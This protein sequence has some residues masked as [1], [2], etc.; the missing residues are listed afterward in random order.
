M[1]ANPLDLH[2]R[3]GYTPDHGKGKI[4]HRNGLSLHPS[5]LGGGTVRISVITPNY[6]GAR[7]LEE[8]IESVAIQRKDGVDVEY[9]VADGGST[10]GSLEILKKRAGDVSVLITEKDTGPANAINKGLKRAS[11]EILCWLNAD[12]KYYAGTLKRISETMA[13]NPDKAICFGHCPIVDEGG[14]EIRV[15]ITR[16]KEMFFPVSSRFTIQCINYV[17]QPAMFFRRIAYE[18]AGPL[19]EDLKCAWDYDLILRLWRCGGGVRVG[20]PPLSVFRWHEKSISGQHFRLQFKEEWDAAATD[21]GRFSPQ[22]LIHLGVR[23]GIVW[24]YSLMALA[25]GRA[26]E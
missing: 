3:V 5:G 9:I 23:W 8:C 7:F 2:N 15:G 1:R 17:S 26:K 25:R 22:A 6:N 21:A 12:D 4:C 18:K 13:R 20:N 16:F 24:S 11:G 14:R 10:D 19:R